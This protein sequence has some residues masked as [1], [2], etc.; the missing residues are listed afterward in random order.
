MKRVCMAMCVASS[1]VW[2]VGV[3]AVT[4]ETCLPSAD[5]QVSAGSSLV[6]ESKTV[7]QGKSVT[8]GLAITNDVALKNIE[9]PLI[10]RELDLGAF[11]TVLTPQRTP[12]GRLASVLRDLDILNTYPSE[13]G[14]CKNGEPGGFF[15]L[16]ATDGISP[17]GAKFAVG[18]IFGPSLQPGADPASGSLQ[19]LMTVNN[20]PGQFEIDTSCC[21]PGCHLVFV[22]DPTASIIPQFTKGIIT[23]STCDCPQQGDINSDGVIDIFD[24]IG[25]LDYQFMNGPEPLRDPA[26]P[27]NRGDALC[28]GFAYLFDTIYLIEHVFCGGPP[29]CDPCACVSYPTDCP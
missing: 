29:P 28:D 18:R 27:T 2:T 24:I 16:G 20:T 21:M 22:Q 9:I 15:H 23:I 7:Y 6:I 3:S 19:L 14:N 4:E 26:C 1:L 8:V 10:I 5:A 17:D 13:D 11:I 25:L 12:G